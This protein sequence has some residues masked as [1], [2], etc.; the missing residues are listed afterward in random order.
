ME[1]AEFPR[2]AGLRGNRRTREP[3]AHG[4]SQSIMYR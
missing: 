4:T 1:Y 3:T 2:H